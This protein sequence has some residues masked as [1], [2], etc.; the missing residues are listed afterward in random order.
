MFIQSLSVLIVLVLQSCLVFIWGNLPFMSTWEMGSEGLSAT[1][2]VDFCRHIML[3]RREG[4]I[5]VKRIQRIIFK[6]KHFA[7]RCMNFKQAGGSGRSWK[8]RPRSPLGYVPVH[9]SDIASLQWDTKL[10]CLLVWQMI[11]KTQRI[12][13]Q[14]IDCF[15]S[16]CWWLHCLVVLGE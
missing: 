7:F 4:V 3:S 11:V 5:S 10:I 12:T 14:G 9:A 13:S 15:L 8:L 2:L 6:K 1:Y 16:N